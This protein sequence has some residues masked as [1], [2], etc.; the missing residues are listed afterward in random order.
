MSDSDSDGDEFVRS[1]KKSYRV[2]K[3]KLLLRSRFLFILPMPLFF[4]GLYSLLA[5][6]AIQMLGRFGGLVLFLLAAW[7]VFEGEKAAYEYDEREVAKPPVMPRKLFASIA[8]AIAAAITALFGFSPICDDPV[9]SMVFALLAGCLHFASFGMDPIKSKGLEGYSEPEAQRLLN[10]LEKGERLVLETLAAAQTF[11]DKSLQV[12][13]ERLIREVRGVFRAIE[14][15]PRD[16]SRARRFMSVYL[17]GA[18]DATVKVAN[19]NRKIPLKAE[20]SEYKALL[21]DLEQQFIQQRE[22][23]LQ[24]DRTELDVEVEVLRDRI[25]QEYRG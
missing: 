17:Q 22:R 7:L 18:R 11:Q 9:G 23:L 1:I 2:I 16:L 4:M 14:K 3:S 6:D 20:F 10:A 15:D 24:N 19:L 12:R 21:V 8:T 5:G 13:V 25:K